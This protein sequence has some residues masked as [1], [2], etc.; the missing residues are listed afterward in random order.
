VI[1]GHAELIASAQDAPSHLRR[2]AEA[3]RDA[4][5]RA[6]R[7]T[8]QLLVFGK[9]QPVKQRSL[10]LNAV[11]GSLESMLRSLA[12]D[13]V[14]LLTDFDPDLDRVKAETGQIEQIMVNLVVNAR[15]AMPNGGTITI[16][17]RNTQLATAP[18]GD[19][20]KFRPGGYV[21]LEVRDTGTGMDEGIRP[22]IFEPFFTTKP[23]L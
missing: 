18:S 13:R 22:R 4:F 3:I 2:S 20:G 17:T 12:G 15:D 8:R 9:P 23:S 1:E 6:A 11:L 7:L 5:E 19:L 21:S 14:A 16:R 10:D